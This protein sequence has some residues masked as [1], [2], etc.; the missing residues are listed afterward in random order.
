[1][2]TWGSLEWSC[3]SA[4][5]LVTVLAEIRS[6]LPIGPGGIGG[7]GGGWGVPGIPGF[8]LSSSFGFLLLLQLL[9]F[10]ILLGFLGGC[11]GCSCVGEGYKFRSF[12]Q[13]YNQL[14][15]IKMKVMGGL[16]RSFQE[17]GW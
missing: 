4:L 11:C 14:V 6:V 7:A 5:L 10:L 13:L 2:T 16:G 12:R 8:L 3:L 9:F 1:M 15:M 17:C